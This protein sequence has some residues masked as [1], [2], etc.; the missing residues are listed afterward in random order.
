[1]QCKMVLSY[2]SYN[3]AKNEDKQE[4]TNLRNEMQ[5]LRLEFKKVIT[6]IQQNPL[7]ANVKPE[8]LKTI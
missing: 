7:L 3:E 4:I 8:V 2:D 1:M 5:D 6:M